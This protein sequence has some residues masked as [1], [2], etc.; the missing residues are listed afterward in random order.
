LPD[1]PLID[2][3]IDRARA[4]IATTHDDAVNLMPCW[5][6]RRMKVSGDPDELVGTRLSHS[7]PEFMIFFN[8]RASRKHLIRGVW[9]AL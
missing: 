6:A 9:N 3:G 5:L 2:A 7:D 8:Q 4:F 1:T